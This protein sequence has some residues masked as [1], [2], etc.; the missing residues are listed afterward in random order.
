MLL[1]GV[2]T[3][4]LDMVVSAFLRLG[5]ADEGDVDIRSL[6]RDMQEFLDQYTNTEASQ[7]DM[8]GVLNSFLTGLRVHHIECPGDLILMIKAL[9]TI[10]GVATELDPTFDLIAAARPHLEKLVRSQ[11]SPEAIKRR[12]RK[13]GMKYI[14]LFEDMPGDL[15]RLVKRVQSDRFRIHLEHR[16]TERFRQTLEHASRNIALAVIV[17]SVM[18]ASSILILADRGD[19]GLVTIFGIVGFASGFTLTLIAGVMALRA[20]RSKM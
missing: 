16:G 13:A 20:P 7:V 5:N 18:V 1:Q 14:E 2:A 8:R 10:E 17:A 11:Y 6:R 12:M 19:K 4:D 9:T 3:S 15:H